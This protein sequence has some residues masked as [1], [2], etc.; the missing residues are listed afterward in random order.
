[1]KPQRFIFIALFLFLSSSFGFSQT[2][3]QTVP[4]N[5]P[6]TAKASPAYAEV[7]LR[8]TEL[9]SELESLLVEYTEDYPKVKELR[10]ETAS[11]Q[12]ELD[13]LLAVNPAESSKLTAALGKLM[14]RKCELNTDLWTLQ[15]E[16]NDQHPDVKRA[17]RKLEIFEAAIKDILQGK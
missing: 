12:K 2:K 3:N 17:K 5:N 7:L 13:V 11:L 16:F 9:L 10:F 15:K 4:A 14:V 6:Q 8:K 1:M